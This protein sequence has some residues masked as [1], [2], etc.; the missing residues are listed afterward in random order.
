[1]SA[2]F[3]FCRL[4]PKGDFENLTEDEK[5]DVC[6]LYLT[7][8]VESI[9]RSGG[10]IELVAAHSVVA[11]FSQPSIEPYS[12]LQ[13]FRSVWEI[14]TRT[15]NIGL[16]LQQTGKP[17]FIISLELDSSEKAPQQSKLKDKASNTKVLL[18]PSVWSQ[19]KS[20]IISEK[21]SAKK[22]NAAYECKE[23]KSTKELLSYLNSLA[24]ESETSSNTI[25]QTCCTLIFLG[26]SQNKEILPE[27][28]SKL[29]HPN[30]NVRISAAQSIAQLSP[31]GHAPSLLAFLDQIEKE[32]SLM[33]LSTLIISLGSCSD[34]KSLLKLKDFLN[35]SDQRI[36]SNTIEALRS[37]EDS[38]VVDLLLPFML[39]KHNRI[40][41]AAAVVLFSKGR[42]E[43]IEVL[44]SMLRHDQSLMRASAAYA[45]GE[46]TATATAE[47]LI[48]QIKNNLN[49][50][51]NFQQELQKCIPFLLQLLDDLDPMVKRQAIVSLNKI[52]DKVSALPLL[53]SIDLGLNSVELSK[54][55]YSALLSLGSHKFIK[56]L[57][58]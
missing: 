47:I 43:V 57:K 24:V 46:L 29:S 1:V 10:E 32:T 22:F 28:Y 15:D 26:Y 52:R 11:H 23:R 58:L 51:K 27:L 21:I 37:C 42:L 45:L 14:L 53:Q 55:L 34:S 48:T 13:A 9:H 41:A 7:E 49:T 6:N 5:R 18:S 33:V 8:I 12:V 20:L 17:F 38:I 36:V 19:I 31:V 50:G 40:K 56:N 25:E 4:N 2:T 35:H 16:L 44:K 54:K 30:E 39:S 3:L